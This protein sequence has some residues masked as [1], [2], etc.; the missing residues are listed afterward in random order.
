A[1]VDPWTGDPLTA[2]VADPAEAGTPEAVTT[3]AGP[4]RARAVAA[5]VRPVARNVPTGAAG[6]GRSVAGPPVRVV[7]PPV[8]PRGEGA[9]GQG[10]TSRDDGQERGGE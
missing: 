3:P 10:D 5:A 2:G 8:A 1:P 9:A 7:A 4:R 6:A